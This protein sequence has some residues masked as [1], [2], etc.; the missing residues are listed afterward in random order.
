MLRA[1][2][3]LLLL[4]NA[5]SVSA[6]T[7][8]A[9]QTAGTWWLST[10]DGK[11]FWSL[12]VCCVDQ[13]EEKY[14]PANPGF[15]ASRIYPT[16]PEW[17][18]ATRDNLRRWGFNSLGGWSDTDRLSRNAGKNSLPYC[19]VLHLGAY[20]HAPWVDLFSPDF[21]RTTDKAAQEQIAKVRDDPNLI[22]YF[23]DNEL[24]WWDETLFLYYFAMKPDTPG[25]QELIKLLQRE[26]RN[27][28]AAF[29]KDWNTGA[30]TFEE[31]AT[32]SQI[33]LRAGG[34]GRRIVTSWVRILAER[35]YAV[36]KRS[37]RKYDTMHL[38]LGDRYAQYYTL[39]VAQAS[40]KFVDVASSNMGAEWNDGTLSR[41][42][43]DTL[44]HATKK[45]ILITEFYMAARENRSGNKN[46]STAFPIVDTQAERAVAFGTNVR[47]LA[48]LPYVVGAHWFQYYD[49][50]THGRKDGEDFNMGLVD[51]HGKPYERLVQT[52]ANLGVET[53]HR[54]ARIPANSTEIPPAPVQPMKGLKAWDR[55]RGFVPPQT[56]LPTADLYTCWDADNLY[57]G[58]FAMDFIDEK[59]YEGER[60]PESERSL[61]TIKIGGMTQPITVRFGG[62]GQKV[63]ANHSDVEATELSG[64]KHSVMI[65]IP[66]RLFHHA[67][68]TEQTTID[69]NAS[70]SL[71]SRSAW[72]TWKQTR[73]LAR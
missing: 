23:T 73:R 5:G 49:E 4:L 14:N 44:H 63:Q 17:V 71:H 53:L 12:G 42:F 38:I 47:A 16:T 15:A 39:P 37:V 11:P 58:L 31:L 9:R 69:L 70:L 45:P 30:K 3:S 35:Y 43:L 72:L 13:G 8:R 55:V 46:S 2:A 19:I 28:V 66:R 21:E 56:K 7:F 60:L 67:A 59:L 50:P 54:T 51:I 61:W 10:P 34:S 18:T 27:D 29:R 6:Q 48:G 65:R 36:V 62:K 25:K 22:G 52:A 64:L 68:L 26:Y 57:L 1:S 32:L 20:Y 33:T 40:A 24:G 41:F